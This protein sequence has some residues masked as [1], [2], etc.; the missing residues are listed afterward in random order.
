MF[1][2]LSKSVCE[3]LLFH[4]Y[5][6][7][8]ILDFSAKAVNKSRP[9]RCVFFLFKGSKFPATLPNRDALHFRFAVMLKTQCSGPNWYGRDCVKFCYPD[10]VRVK[11]C[12]GDGDQ[13]CGQGKYDFLFASWRCVR[14]LSPAGFLI[15]AWNK[16]SLVNCQIDLART[17]KSQ[18]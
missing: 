6:R 13:V 10:G 15:I 8:T 14:F 11:K 3:L 12:V 7:W 17:C 16:S 18:H 2:D 5:T 9:Q 4:D 1:I